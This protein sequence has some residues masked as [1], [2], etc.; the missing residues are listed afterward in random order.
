MVGGDGEADE[1][2]I[3]FDVMVKAATGSEAQRI[4]VGVVQLATVNALVVSDDERACFIEYPVVGTR[5]LASFRCGAEAVEHAQ[6]VEYLQSHSCCPQSAEVQAPE[7]VGRQYVVLVAVEGDTSVA[8]GQM[9]SELH[10]MANGHPAWP[11]SLAC[12]LFTHFCI[13]HYLVGEV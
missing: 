10:G 6:V 12:S 2:L 4:F 9:R 1:E 3:G 8:C 11:G 7:L 5:P 13:C